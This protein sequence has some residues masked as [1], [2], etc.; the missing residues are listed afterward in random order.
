MFTHSPVA[1]LNPTQSSTIYKRLQQMVLP[2][3]KACRNMYLK[4]PDSAIGESGFSSLFGVLELL[5]LFVVSMASIA[6]IL[7]R[8]CN[9]LKILLCTLNILN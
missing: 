6:F 7:S 8:F 5:S 9:A 1:T 3:P 4:R 2:P